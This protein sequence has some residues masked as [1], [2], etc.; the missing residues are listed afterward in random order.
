MSSDAEMELFKIMQEMRQKYTYFLLAGV[1]ACVG[2]AVTQTKDA[3]VSV[4]MIPLGVAVFCWAL[5]FY[6]GCRYLHKRSVAIGANIEVLKLRGGRNPMAG[7]NV[8][9]IAIGLDVMEPNYKM[10]NNQGTFAYRWQ[11]RFFAAAG[12]AF[13][14]WHILEMWQRTAT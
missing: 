1:A 11:F 4:Q 6:F 13:L 5:S 3:Q 2:F 7:R 12:L 9:K 8:E 14:V 10:A